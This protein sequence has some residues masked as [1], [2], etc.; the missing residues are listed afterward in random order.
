[1]QKSDEANAQDRE[2][3]NQLARLLNLDHFLQVDEGHRSQLK[4]FRIGL[5]F[6]DASLERWR[7]SGSS[8]TSIG[9]Q[10]FSKEEYDLIVVL[11]M[12][13]YAKYMPKNNAGCQAVSKI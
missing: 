11:Y 5:C 1:M 10:R 13:L 2:L 4:I 7:F 9:Y 6:P 3:F 8:G 12:Y